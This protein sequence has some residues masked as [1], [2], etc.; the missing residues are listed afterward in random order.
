MNDMEAIDMYAKEL[1]L[2]AVRENAALFSEDAIREQWGHLT[3]LKRLLDGSGQTAGERQD[4]S[5]PQ[6]LFPADEVP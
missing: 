6:G 4:D 1:R 3:F 2:S 5:H